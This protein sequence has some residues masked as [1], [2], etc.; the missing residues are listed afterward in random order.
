MND[1]LGKRIIT[2]ITTAQNLLDEAYDNMPEIPQNSERLEQ[3]NDVFYE[4]DVIVDRIEELDSKLAE[5]FE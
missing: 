4:L 3:M 2:L 5:L 1:E